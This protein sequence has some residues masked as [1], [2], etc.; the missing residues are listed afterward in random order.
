MNCSTSDKFHP[1][2]M[3]NAVIAAVLPDKSVQSHDAKLLSTYFLCFSKC[4][5]SLSNTVAGGA[6]FT[7][8][9]L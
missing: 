3:N 8:T 7:S 5:C 4:V 6:S 9:S 2:F 1:D